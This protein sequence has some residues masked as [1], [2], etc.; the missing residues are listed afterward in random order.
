MESSPFTASDREEFARLGIE[1]EKALFSSDSFRDH[2][3]ISSSY[4]PVP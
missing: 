2:L 4:G 1:E 3:L